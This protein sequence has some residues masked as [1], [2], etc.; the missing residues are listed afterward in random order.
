MTNFKKSDYL[1]VYGTLRQGPRNEMHQLLVRHARYVGK[2]TFQGKLYKVDGYP[3][4]VPSPN[5]ADIVY[6]EVYRLLQPSLVLAELDAYEECS[7]GFP[8]PT[9]YKR[10][11][12]MIT[13]Q[14]G[15]RIDAWMY[16]YNH[17]IANLHLIGSG[18]FLNG[19][20]RHE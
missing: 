14:S 12:E 5:P 2:A 13:L 10:C 4:V 6:G 19:H 16:I 9:E 11:K 7:P 15:D 17:P 18:D 1:F 8:E 3:G 20:W